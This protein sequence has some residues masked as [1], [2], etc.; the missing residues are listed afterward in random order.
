[1]KL[2]FD[3]N[4][5]RK[6]AT[7]LAELY[8]NSRH[9]SD[10]ELLQCKD[11]AIWN[12]AKANGFIIVTTDS[13]FLI[14]QLLWDRLLKW[15]GFAVGIIRLATWKH[16]YAVKQCASPNLPQI[17]NLPYWF[18]KRGNELHPKV[19]LVCFAG[20]EPSNIVEFLL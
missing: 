4:L 12:Y 14:S 13:D 15:S 7:R 11:Y 16:Y 20:N 19:L 5:S 3:E 17:L 10:A 8:P 9:V 1:M 6:L 18:W 2:L